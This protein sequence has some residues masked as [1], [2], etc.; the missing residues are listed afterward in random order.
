MIHLRIYLAS[1][2][3]LL[4]GAISSPSPLV[5]AENATPCLHKRAPSM[6]LA[7][8]KYAPTLPTQ[9]KISYYPPPCF[10]RLTHVRTSK[11]GSILVLTPINHIYHAD[12]FPLRSVQSTHSSLRWKLCCL[13][14]GGLC[15]WGGTEPKQIEGD[16]ALLVS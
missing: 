8:S 4:P 2:K 7:T 6:I 15:V 9:F 13:H 11:T 10:S 1:N 16:D 12:P 3:K 5:C 14:L